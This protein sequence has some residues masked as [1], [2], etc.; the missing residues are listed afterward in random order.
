[1]FRAESP[2]LDFRYRIKAFGEAEPN[3]KI[4]QPPSP[5]TPLEGPVSSRT[6][7]GRPEKPLSFDAEVFGAVQR[8]EVLL[9]LPPVTKDPPR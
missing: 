8:V 2:L 7:P 5:P 6:P 1:M 3:E 9:S 4:H